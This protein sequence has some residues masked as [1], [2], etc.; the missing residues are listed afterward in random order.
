MPDPADRSDLPTRAAVLERIALDTRET[1]QGIRA[2][3]REMPAEPRGDIRD[4]RGE[5]KAGFA[6][7][8]G[9]MDAGF[10]GLHSEMAGMRADSR[11][12]FRW[13]LGIMLGSGAILPGM[14]AHGF[15]WL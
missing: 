10:A 2:D 13:L 11:L 6:D 14:M 7:L 9:E 12:Q 5:M 8:R 4:L 1:L 3:M 15:H